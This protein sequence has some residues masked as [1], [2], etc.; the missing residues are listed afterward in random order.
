[1][2]VSPSHS[3][4]DLCNIRT[5]NVKQE[6]Q[7]K[8]QFYNFNLPKEYAQEKTEVIFSISDL[9]LKIACLL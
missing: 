7:I 6:Q 9:F 3:I 8:V 4:I 5:Q 1:M 2:S